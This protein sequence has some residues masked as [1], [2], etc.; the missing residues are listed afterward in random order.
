MDVLRKLAKALASNQDKV[1]RKAQKQAKVLLSK[2]SFNG[3]DPTEN[4]SAVINQI[5]NI[6][7]FKTSRRKIGGSS[8]LNV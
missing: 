8:T 7:L 3:K 1:R 6:S 5:N 4:V 2:K